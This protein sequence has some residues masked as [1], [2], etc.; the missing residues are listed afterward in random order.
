MSFHLEGVT[1]SEVGEA[2]RWIR[3]SIPEW[4][5]P[6]DGDHTGAGLAADG[7]GSAI[8]RLQGPERRPRVELLLG[9]I[10]W[11]LRRRQGLMLDR[12]NGDC[13]RVRCSRF[14]LEAGLAVSLDGRG[15]LLC[16][17]GRGLP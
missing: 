6:N 11:D 14:A 8:V 17:V 13:S 2:E 10:G 16:G 3:W 15:L 12:M 5:G 9:L 4:A 7:W 1:D